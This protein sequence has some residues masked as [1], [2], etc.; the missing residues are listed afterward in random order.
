MRKLLLFCLL[1]PISVLAQTAARYDL[2]ILTTI[3]SNTPPNTLPPLDAITNAQIAVCG[4]PATLSAGMCTNTIS[5]YTDASLTT[6][7]PSSAQ[8]TY[9]GTNVCVSTSGLQ[10]QFGFWYNASANGHLTYTVKTTWGTFGPFDI[11]APTGTGGGGG[12]PGTGSYSPKQN[13][14]PSQDFTQCITAI[15]ALMPA[16]GG[17]ID[18]DVL[19]GPASMGTPLHITKPLQLKMGSYQVV[20]NCADQGVTSG[21]LVIDPGVSGVQILGTNINGHA[22]SFFRASG[23]NL[24]TPIWLSGNSDH[25]W[26]ENLFFDGNEGGQN[27]PELTCFYT[28]LRSDPLNGG[29]SDL[30]LDHDEFARGGDRA[31]DLRATHRV[32]MNDIYS[33]DCGINN[34]NKNFGCE[35]LSVDAGGA[36]NNTI[37]AAVSQNG[38][39]GSGYPTSGST[40][41][42]SAPGAGGIQ[43][44]GTPIIQNGVP[45]NPA[46]TAQGSG[47]QSAPGVLITDTGTG[48]GATAHATITGTVNGTV[49]QTAGQYTGTVTLTFN[50]AVGSGAILSSTF[51]GGVFTGCSVVAGGSLYNPSLTGVQF[52]SAT[53]T[54]AFAVLTIVGGVVT[55]CTDVN[56]GQNYANTDTASVISLGG[57]GG[58][59]TAALNGGGGITGCQ[60]G[61]L[62][63]GVGYLSNPSATITTTGTVITPGAVLGTLNFYVNTIVLDQTFG[64]YT[65]PSCQFF[66]GGGTG[67]ACSIGVANG[68]FIGVAMT[69]VGNQYYTPSAGAPTCTVSGTGGSGALCVPQQGLVLYYPSDTF[70]NNIEVDNYSDSMACARGTGCHINNLTMKGIPYFGGTPRPTGGG[71]DVGGCTNCTFNNILILGVNGPQLDFLSFTVANQPINVQ[72]NTITNFISDPTATAPGVTPVDISKYDQVFEM[73]AE[74]QNS[75]CNHITMS[76]MQFTATRMEIENCDHVTLHGSSFRNINPVGGLNAAIDVHQIPFVAQLTQDID[77]SNNTFQTDNS[78]IAFGVNYDPQLIGNSPFTQNNNIYDGAIA[79]YQSIGNAIAPSLDIQQMNRKIVTQYGTST[80]HNFGAEFDARGAAGTQ[81]IPTQLA[82]NSYA[83]SLC[84]NFFSAQGQGPYADGF[85]PGGCLTGIQLTT[86]SGAAMSAA[87]IMQVQDPLGSGTLVQA[88]VWEPGFNISRQTFSAPRVNQNAAGQFATSLALSSATTGSFPFPSA[89]TSAPVCTVT[90]RTSLGSTTLS[91]SVSTTGVTLTLST[92]FTGT[93]D[94]SCTGNP[95]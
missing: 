25:I 30:H 57:S 62:V 17:V 93:F 73:G 55:Q 66:G 59:C 1:L 21:C 90:S 71:L 4:F 79:P 41:T 31:L 49:V 50:Q 40:V 76:N 32:W 14:S 65:L 36:Y 91:Y 74:T 20:M 83:G 11:L 15:E 16:N 26:F 29:V 92:A 47:F 68:V 69:N 34:P 35:V 18:A 42:F 12:S 81:G 3:S 44:T 38:A 7:C 95:N 56:G 84:F 2:P 9:N 5:T 28:F 27:C 37:G 60:G 10:G 39:S 53:G 22:S 43:A 24:E 8:L 13:C 58:H 77:V 63:G 64:G 88:E 70:M 19:V 51:A 45:V 80:G 54:G 94:I 33:H 52:N 46:I 72:N 86:P 78:S 89:Y 75:T 6:V 87:N 82:N 61:T 85:I 23:T 48:K 67:A